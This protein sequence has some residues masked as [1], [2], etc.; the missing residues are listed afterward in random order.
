[1]FRIG[2]IELGVT[3]ALVSLAIVIPLLVTRGYAKLNKRIKN[4]E[5][6]VSKKH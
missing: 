1:M 5:E 3:C 2:I 6:R 4:I